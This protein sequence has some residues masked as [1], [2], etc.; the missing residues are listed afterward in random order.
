MAVFL[1]N[2]QSALIGD[3]AGV[4]SPQ[5]AQ[6]VTDIVTT[7]V[8]GGWSMGW[9]RRHGLGNLQWFSH[10]GSN[11]GTGG[12]VYATMEN[13]NGI[14]FFGN[15]PNQVRIP[16]LNQLRNSIIR[17]HGWY[18]PLD[19]S[20]AKELPNEFA[21][22]LTGDYSHLLFGEVARLEKLNGALVFR[23]FVPGKANADLMYIGDQTF[24]VDEYSAAIRFESLNDTLHIRPHHFDFLKESAYSFKKTGE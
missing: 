9:E 17:A 11:T 15:G 20:K 10:G 18:K 8:M 16:V 12:H 19:E 24:M 2:I 3:T 5:V 6:R 21:Q 14:A 1:I 4:I 7:D 22:K 23:N 13:G